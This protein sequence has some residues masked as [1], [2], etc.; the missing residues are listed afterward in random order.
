MPAGQTMIRQL[1]GWIFALF[2][3]A[4]LMPGVPVDALTLDEVIAKAKNEGQVRLGIAPRKEIS[5]RPVASR[6]FEGFQRRYPFIKINYQRVSG[7]GQ[8]ER[9]F[10]EMAGGVVNYDV[11]SLSTR[12]IDDGIKANIFQAVDWKGVGVDPQSVH[13]ANFGVTYRMEPYGI[14]YNTDLIK[15]AEGQKLTWEDCT[16]PKWKGKFATIDR[17]RHLEV[18]Y[19]NNAWGREKTLDYAR[20]LAANNPIVERSRDE[21]FVKLVK[22]AYPMLCGDRSQGVLLENAM[23]V[24]NVGITFPEPVPIVHVTFMFVPRGAKNSNAGILWIAWTL[25]E[26]GQKIHD[27]AEFT[28]NPM[29]PSS[30]VHKRIKG[31]K[32]PGISW[33]FLSRSDDILREV[34]TAMGFPVVQ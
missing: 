33:D 14:S 15:E 34:L 18:L 29:L 25:S 4:V 23:G 27:E 11:A 32:I 8:R 13:P 1:G 12:Q 24:K 10:S 2:V 6:I 21:A 5:G 16:N 30:A 9:V 3:G 26:E 22:G 31:K 28:G 17:P 20:R 19:Q 7:F